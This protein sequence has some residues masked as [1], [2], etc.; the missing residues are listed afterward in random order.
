MSR[1]EGRKGIPFVVAAPS[2]TG[3]T[4][5]CRAVL[6][7]D[8]GIRFSVSHTTREPRAGERDGADYHFVSPQQFGRLVEEGGFLEHAEYG[9]NCYGTGSRELEETLEAGLDLLLEIE[10]QGAGQVRERRGDARFIFLLPPDMEVLAERLRLRGTDSPETIDRRLD[11]ARQ[12][13]AAVDLFDYAVV[14]DRLEEAVDSVIEIVEAERSGRPDAARE[15]HGRI[16]VLKGWRG[17]DD[18][19]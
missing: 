3:K 15:R 7:R 14:N 13:L 5:V 11:L 6:E 12:E 18:P 2:G 9:G 10:V 19:G 8:P 4:T 1:P 16:G 17:R